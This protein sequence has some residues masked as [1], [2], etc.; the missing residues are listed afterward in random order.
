MKILSIGNSFSQNAQRYLHALCQHNGKY[1]KTVNLFIGGCS[2][3]THYL[4]MLNDTAAYSYVYNG[5]STGLKVSLAAAL[6]SDNWDIV[7]LQQ[8]SPDSPYYNTYSPYIEELSAYVK[9]YCPHAK[10]MIHETWAYEEGSDRL[11]KTMRFASADDMLAAVR[12]SYKQA[13]A[14]ISADGI[15][16]AGEAMLLA[17]KEG[18]KMH[19]DTAHASRGAG[20]YLLAL[21]WYYT[22]TGRDIDGD[23]F[24]AIDPPIS[25]AER[26]IIIR[27]VKA[28]T[29]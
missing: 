12:E 18:V 25:E 10:I 1:M 7:T 11:H 2:L 26:E 9:K 29:I 13:A 27:A 23:T 17:A 5:E 28:A 24:D 21:C 6:S 22:L 15:I 16:P 19:E 4:N 8:A 20:C 3:R 14:A